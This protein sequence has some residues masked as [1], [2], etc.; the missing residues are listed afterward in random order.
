[1]R[2]HADGHV[3]LYAWNGSQLV[4]GSTEG[5]TASFA[6]GVLTLS[7]PRIPTAAEAPFECRRELALTPLG[8]DEIVASNYAPNAGR[9]TYAGPAQAA[10]PIR[11]AITMPR[12]TDVGS[13]HRRESGWIT[14]SHAELRNASVRVRDRADHRCRLQP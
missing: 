13:C 6:S 2:Y 4:A 11:P 10:F 9:S 12:P 5:I 3:E 14:Q 8:E 1:M 7:L